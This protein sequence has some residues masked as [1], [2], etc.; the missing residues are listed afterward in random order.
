M[1]GLGHKIHFKHFQLD[2][3][4]DTIFAVVLSVLR[5]SDRSYIGITES[6]VWRWS[7]CE[8]WNDMVAHRNNG[9]DNMH[10]ICCDKPMCIATLDE[11]VID[12]MFE[13]DS[14]ASTLQGGF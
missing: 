11:M 14:V 3:T 6:P 12:H 13:C 1:I 4:K 8:G 10:V 7:E 2:W 9:F 5:K